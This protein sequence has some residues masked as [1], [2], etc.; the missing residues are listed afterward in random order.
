MTIH[1]ESWPTEMS[2]RTTRWCNISTFYWHRNLD[3]T[4]VLYKEHS[5]DSYRIC[6]SSCQPYLLMIVCEGMGSNSSLL[7]LTWKSAFKNVYIDAV[8][9]VGALSKASCEM[10]SDS[11]ST[12][13]TACLPLPVHLPCPSCQHSSRLRVGSSPV[14]SLHWPSHPSPSLFPKFLCDFC[15]VPR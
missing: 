10:N 1:P 4:Q 7:C 14:I 3:R 9:R 11:P 2:N 8:V 5:P 15:F 13:S 12:S 6:H